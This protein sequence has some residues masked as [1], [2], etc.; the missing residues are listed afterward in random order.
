MDLKEA[1]GA[2]E[3][4]LFMASGPLEIREIAR[5]LEIEPPIIRRIIDQLANEYEHRGGG[6]EIV[7]IAGG[8]QMRTRVEY[9]SWIE[10]FYGLQR[11]AK[12][13]RP[14]LETLA[15]IAYHQPITKAEIETIRGVDVQ[16]SLK[17]LLEKNLIKI[18]GR[19]KV[20]GRPLLYKT[21]KEFLRYFGLASL[22]DLPKLEELKELS[23]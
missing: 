7:E 4:I 1:K 22:D 11:E 20:I 10:R 12:L 5:I 23:G 8:Y 6:L 16:A 17:R 9:A 14:T 15:I 2:I 21:T 19:K 13:S 3:A 18:A